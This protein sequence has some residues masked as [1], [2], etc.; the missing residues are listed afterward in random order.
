MNINLFF[1]Y[2]ALTYQIKMDTATDPQ[3]VVLS[4]TNSASLVTPT[5]SSITYNHAD[6]LTAE[7]KYYVKVSGRDNVLLEGFVYKYTETFIC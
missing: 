5:A 7:T 6:T 2:E 1:L 3:T 4:Y